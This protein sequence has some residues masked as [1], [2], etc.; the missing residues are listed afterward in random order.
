MAASHSGLGENRD[1]P[2][3]S[4]IGLLWG[5]A[6]RIIGTENRA[7]T[8]TVII[9]SKLTSNPFFLEFLCMRCMNQWPV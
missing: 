3:N 6:Y 9:V 2:C 5:G 8:M 7:Q 1:R 4:I